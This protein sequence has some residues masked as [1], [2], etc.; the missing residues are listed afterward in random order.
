M[1]KKRQRVEEEEVEEERYFLNPTAVS[2]HLYCSICQEVFIEPQRAPCGHSYCKKCI[3][4]WLHKSKTCPDD[5]K[6]VQ[7]HQLHFDFILANIIGDQ[8]VACPYR[9]SGCL[10]IGQLEQLA[11]HK[12]SCNFNPKNLPAFLL[13][14]KENLTGHDPTPSSSQQCVINLDESVE[15]EDSGDEDDDDVLPTPAKPSLKMRLFQ[16]GGGQRELLCS[17]FKNSSNKR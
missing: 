11:S 16:N 4:P 12:K 5:R 13:A 9:K 10:H 7:I 6:P 8:M 15:D 1:F 14:N 3:L 2:R 17:M